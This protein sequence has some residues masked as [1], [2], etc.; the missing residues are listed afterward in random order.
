MAPTGKAMTWT[1]AAF[2]DIRCGQIVEM[3]AEIS[4]LDRLRQL[5]VLATE[6]PAAKMAG[7]GAPDVAADGTPGS[8]SGATPCAAAGPEALRAVVERLRAEVYGEGDFQ[9]MPEIFTADYRHGSANGPDAS[10]I[11]DGARRIGT[12]VSGFPDLEWTFDDVIVQGD[13][14]SA[15]WTT[16]GTHDGDLA[17]FAAT[18]KPV[19]FTGISTF[20]FQCGKMVE[21]QTEMDAAGMLEQVGAPVR[22]DAG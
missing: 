12:F 5:G 1:Q 3:W 20:F 2:A 16:R 21:F 11:E 7:D 22:S 17:G 9:I 13:R 19:A 15:R 8:A 18:G 14:V 10:G 4:Q 6:G